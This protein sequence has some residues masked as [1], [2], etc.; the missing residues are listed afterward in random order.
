[1]VKDKA[2]IYLKRVNK[3][4]VRGR[5]KNYWIE[6][7]K[8]KDYFDVLIGE[9]GEKAHIH[10]GINPDTTTKFIEDRGKIMRMRKE[11]IGLDGGKV[12]LN[13]QKFFNKE[14]NLPANLLISFDYKIK[15][16]GKNKIYTAFEK[17]TISE[18]KTV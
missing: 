17:I 10:F 14:P 8:K 12:L 9:K 16:I 2:E 13:E 1:M 7:R 15:K 3:N 5:T 6:V 4:V 18:R 11:K